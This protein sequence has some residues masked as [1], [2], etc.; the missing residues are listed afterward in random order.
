MGEPLI[1]SFVVRIYADSEAA[2]DQSPWRVT[3]RHVQSDEEHQF[4]SLEDAS[5]WMNQFAKEVPNRG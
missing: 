2:A 1:A 5:V 3:V 4:I